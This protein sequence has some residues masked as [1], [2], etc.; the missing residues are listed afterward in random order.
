MGET[1]LFA[2]S[3]RAPNDKT[4]SFKVALEIIPKQYFSIHIRKPLVKKGWKMDIVW[5]GEGGIYHVFNSLGNEP[6]IAHW[7]NYVQPHNLPAF[8]Q[9]KFI[10]LMSDFGNQV[11]KIDWKV[12]GLKLSEMDFAEI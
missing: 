2:T 7:K 5:K 3:H 4:I 9:N 11:K 1:A 8:L 6:Y 12:N 10:G